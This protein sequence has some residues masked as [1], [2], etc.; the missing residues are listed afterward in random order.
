[1]AHGGNGNEKKRRIQEMT[2]LSPFARIS[3]RIRI[4][5]LCFKME[6]EGQ[7][8]VHPYIVHSEELN[9]AQDF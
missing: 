5:N 9:L 2:L 4:L 3:C 1:M 7:N 6:T 8:E